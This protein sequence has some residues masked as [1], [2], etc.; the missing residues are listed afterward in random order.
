MEIKT[1]DVY[2]PVDV[3]E[4][5][6]EQMFNTVNSGDSWTVAY[7]H[8]DVKKSEQ[9]TDDSHGRHLTSPTHWLEKKSDMVVLTID[10]VKEIY[11][12]GY[13]RRNSNNFSRDWEEFK[14]LHKL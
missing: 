9:W 5:S 11:I 3:E 12:E 7:F 4:R 10:Q 2:L 13:K 8:K 1:Q 14:T 6:P